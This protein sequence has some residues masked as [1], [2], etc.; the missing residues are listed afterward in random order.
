[1]SVLVLAG[2]GK[3]TIATQL[4]AHYA[5]GGASVVLVDASGRRHASRW[6]ARRLSFE[7]AP[8]IDLQ[9]ARGVLGAALRTLARRYEHVIVDAADGGQELATALLVADGVLVPFTPSQFD[10]E[11]LRD[12]AGDL[13]VARDANPAL[14]A[15]AVANCAETN[16]TRAGRAREAIAWLTDAC[17]VL[18][19]AEQVVSYRPAAIQESAE[20]GL[21]VFERTN[22]SAQKA[23]DQLAALAREF[24]ALRPGAA[25]INTDEGGGDDGI[26]RQ[27]AG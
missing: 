7:H 4:A 23:A 25:A 6:T 26:R 19:C 12:L 18:C 14:H 22:L 11:G 10:L 24:D 27:Q 15:V 8:R 13:V 17:P 3:T 9:P 5:I 2:Y 16:W 20:T 21:S 1:M